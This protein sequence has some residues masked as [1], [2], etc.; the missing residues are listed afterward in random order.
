MPYYLSQNNFS[1]PSTT[2]MKKTI[3]GL[4]VL[5][6]LLVTQQVSGQFLLLDDMEGNG[7][8][9]GRW[10][11]YAGGAGVTGSVAFNVANPSPGGLNSS[12]HVARFIKDTTCFEYMSAGVNMLDSFD[13]RGTSVFKMLVYA[14]VK[15]DIMF[16]LQ[17]GNDHTK[18]VYFTYRVSQVNSWEE[19]TF[20][21]QSVSQRTNFNRIEVHFIDGRKANGTLYFDLVQGPN[22]TAI[23]LLPTNIPMGAENGALIQAK[24][25]GDI[26]APTLSAA[27]WTGINL[28]A[29]VSI[30]S[31]SRLNDT[32]ANIY[33][34]GNSPANYSKATFS[35]TVNGNQLANPNVPSYTAKGKVVFD[36]NPAWT[37]IY[38]DE[39]SLNGKPN[40]AKWKVDPQ[41]KGWIN[42]EQQVYTDSSKN[43]ARIENGKLIIAGKKD[44][45][46]GIPTEP[47]SS[48]RVI[49]QNRMDFQYGKVE[50]RARLPRA[51]GSWPAIWLMPTSSAYGAWPRSGEID[52][53]EHVG[54]NF[55]NV[56][57]T[58]HTQN[59]NWMNG[60]HLSDNMSIPDADTVFHTYSLEWTA[61]SLH[62]MYDSLSVY[63][64][65]NP[66]TDWKDWPFDQ[67]FHVILNVA[68]GGG[69]GGNVV[70]GDWPD[71]MI[72]DYVRIYQ[73]GLGT[74]YLD[75]VTVS[76]KDVSILPGKTQQ[77]TAA[78]FDQN[79]NPITV[80]PVW[81]VTGA[82]NSITSGGLATI[83][84][85]GV[86]TAAATIDT[87]TLSGTT[88]VNV[89]PTNYKPIPARIEAE[90]FDNSN[91]CCTEP[92]S[93]ESGNLNVSYIGV[94]SWM[95]YD[96]DVPDSGA[97]RI[98]FRVAAN[99]NSS[100]RIIADTTVLSTLS[101][102]ASG[103]WQT[104]STVTSAPLVFGPGQK[105]I[106]ITANTSG[107]NFNWLEFVPADSVVLGSIRVKPDSARLIAG[108]SLL[109]T[110]SGFDAA[111]S[112][113]AI[114]PAATWTISGTGNTI[115]ATGWLKT[116][117]IG[118][119]TITAAAGTVTDTAFVQ[120]R[121]VPVLTRVSVSPDSTTVPPGAS[122]QFTAIGY[123]QNDS[124]MAFTPQW[125]VNG[126]GNTI[127]AT[128]IMT[129]GTVPADYKVAV[130]NGSI[131][132]T[133]KVKV[134]YGCT[135]NN[136]HEAESTSNRHP[137][138]WLETSSD[139]GGGQNF[140]GLAATHW[141]A[142]NTLNVPVAGRYT[143]SLRVSS[144]AAA[145]VR[146]GHSGLNFGEIDIP[147]TGGQWQT[148][149]DTM[150]LPALT[151]TG[152][153]VVSGSFKFN[154]WNISNCAVKPQVLT[155]ME[156]N[157]ASVILAPDETSLFAVT[158]FDEEDAAM[159]VTG[160]TWSVSGSLNSVSAGGIVTAGDS[161]GVFTVSY[162]K[163]NVT[164]TQD[165]G[166]LN[167]AVKDKYEAESASNRHPSPYLQP[168]TD[169]GGGQN[170]AGVYSGHWFAYNALNVP[171]AGVYKIRLRVSSTAA[172]QIR[173]GHSSF[174]YKL[175][176]IPS[177]GGIWQT[178]EDTLTL[179]ALSYTGI[180]ILSGGFRFN[181]FSIDNC[182]PLE[183][184]SRGV[185]P[186]PGIDLK[187]SGR[188]SAN[189][190]PVTG[191]VRVQ[192]PV[193]GYRILQVLDMTGKSVRS[194]IINPQS[195]GIDFDMGGLK[196]GMYLLLFT[197]KGNDQL[198]VKVIKE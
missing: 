142:Y 15:E 153:T 42:G 89:R 160:G 71:S 189:P 146:I 137:S 13:L 2:R 99:T 152:V 26:Y 65:V 150:T 64:Y 83:N 162:V 111:G 96:I 128:G 149:S 115:T 67:K 186:A 148:I 6:C 16:K 69:M 58:V 28:P 35:A 19:A 94:N 84:T 92:S 161:A 119:Y 171:S 79:G 165:F 183:P 21:F 188:V 85:S 40:P 34:A 4:A 50:V 129:A 163:G 126:P 178:I 43:N 29:G 86:V 104:W 44:F 12:S 38:N 14:S 173:I 134:A 198:S 90:L 95:E 10:T 132:A 20:N 77:F 182:V 141:F 125:L 39:F 170:F 56:L 196:S 55:G 114:S 139:V 130:K 193:Q 73:K 24:V 110:V 75:S 185:Q 138:P 102:P 147:N 8:C 48:A 157:P 74:P 41:P 177:T 121:P 172:S 18:A 145:R 88:T 117:A 31:V 118:N 93:D 61:D 109:Y 131:T 158:G 78:A 156:V 80:T 49:S 52:I 174:T 7:P 62:F 5:L 135:V 25:S 144:T 184:A 179:P 195:T 167:C 37:M 107:W 54:N 81:S 17:T 154:W 155:R 36:G 164:G 72:V 68:I 140:A 112:P 82:G 100:L 76:P 45:P 33:L 59:N 106:R 9:A 91:V 192:L 175:M 127:S 51:R 57:S 123:D 176:S 166:I 180:H 97:Y 190:N 70:E 151:Y 191:V 181:W 63:T 46:N 103:G 27:A 47:W 122:V 101:L 197:G 113:M 159:P 3:A 30:G 124:V 53:M 98:R 23:N 22:P 11:W 1:S 120:V 143:V 187:T 194:S 32:I 87:I 60:G 116:A 108:D 66:H 105:T 169:I 136:K 168:C 133:A